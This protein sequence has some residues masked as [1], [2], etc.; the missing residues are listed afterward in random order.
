MLDS[1]I[2]TGATHDTKV[3]LERIKYVKTKYKLS[4]KEA[5]ADRGYGAIDNIKSL[6]EKGITTYIPLFSSRVGVTKRDERSWVSIR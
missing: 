3:Y 4:I 5:I 6:N 1:K 2:I